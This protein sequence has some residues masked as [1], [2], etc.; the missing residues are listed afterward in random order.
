MPAIRT[1]ALLPLEDGI[2]MHRYIVT[3]IRQDLAKRGGRRLAP[4]L[5]RQHRPQEQTG[6]SVPAGNLIQHPN[7]V[8]P[9]G[10]STSV[11]QETAD[12]KLIEKGELLQVLPG[13][14]IDIQRMLLLHH[15]PFQK[16]GSLVLPEC[17]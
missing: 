3:G 13:K 1:V 5:H 9:L 7:A 2:G 16:F 17:T 15:P 14:G 6:A 4:L 11:E 8:E 10:M 12:L